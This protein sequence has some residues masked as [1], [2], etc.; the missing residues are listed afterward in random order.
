MKKLFLL[1]LAIPLALVMMGS[2]CDEPTDAIDAPNA[3]TLVGDASNHLD[4]IISWSPSSTSDIDGYRVYFAGATEPLWE[5]MGTSFTHSSPTLGTYEIVAYMDDDESD[6]LT[7]DT[8]DYVHMS[9]GAEIYRFDVSGQ[10][11]A[12][13]WDLSNGSG[14]NKNFTTANAG[15]ID[16]W[17]DNDETINS[18]SGYGGDFVNVT[19]IY[20]SPT[21]Y[22]SISTAPYIDDVSYNNFEDIGANYSYCVYIK[23]QMAYGYYGKMEITDWDMTAHKITFS[24]TIQTI[25]KWRLLD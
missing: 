3:A 7:F 24:W 15:E 2:D 11:S 9:T 5:G 12:Y 17:Y 20:T 21:T 16:I 1:L 4:L 14:A 25:A 13:G 23:K 22:S 18:C 6:P 10:P 8:E 19:G